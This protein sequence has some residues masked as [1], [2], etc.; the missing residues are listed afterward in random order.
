V[1]A[2]QL[3]TPWVAEQRRPASPL[4][5]FSRRMRIMHVVDRAAVWRVANG[6]FLESCAHDPR[7]RLVS[8]EAL[9]TAPEETL[10]SVCD[11]LGEEYDA[12]MLARDDRA[13]PQAAADAGSFADWR[14]AHREAAKA[15]VTR[16]G[17]SKWKGVLSSVEVAM[18]EAICERPMRAAGYE[19]VTRRLPRMAGRAAAA[20]CL[21][22][23]RAEDGMRGIGETV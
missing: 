17:L 6:R 10:R 3:S 13:E 19:A 7:V 18:I 20:V 2:S 22:V 14:R 16:S 5:S 8:Y 23:L 15:S 1:V 4:A 11:F 9:V 12:A 21:A